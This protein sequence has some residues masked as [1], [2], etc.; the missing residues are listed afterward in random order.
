M[1]KRKTEWRKQL[2]SSFALLRHF[3]KSNFCMLYT[4]WK[5]R[6]SR[7]QRFK[8]CMIWSWNEEDMAFRR[9]LHQAEGQFRTLRNWNSN[10]RNLKWMAAV[11]S[12]WSPTCES[13]FGTCKLGSQRAKVDS[14]LWNQL[15]KFSQVTMQRAKLGF[16][17]ADSF[18]SD[19]LCLN[20]HF[21]LV[22]SHSCNYLAKKYSRKGKLLS[23]KNSLVNT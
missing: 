19:I 20:L 7:I 4:I 14:K 10:V 22:F 17:C 13:D 1:E 6:K 5:L 16:L 12:L 8:P 3:P 2:Q 11:H 9:Q 21:L 23:Y 15:A 18:S